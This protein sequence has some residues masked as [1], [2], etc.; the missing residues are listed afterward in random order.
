MLLIDESMFIT[1]TTFSQNR[2]MYN[3]FVTG[4]HDHTACFHCEF[5]RLRIYLGKNMQD[6]SLNVYM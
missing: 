6:G 5:G 1:K 2:V 4:R 3:D